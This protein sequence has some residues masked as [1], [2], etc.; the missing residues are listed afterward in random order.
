[1]V[2]T[3]I[4]WLEARDAEHTTEHKTASQCPQT[5]STQAQMPFC[6]LTGS[7]LQ[8]DHS[9]PARQNGLEGRQ[10]AG[11]ETIWKATTQSREEQ[12]GTQGKLWE[13]ENM[14]IIVM[15]VS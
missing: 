11:K 8:K 13:V 4:Q 6:E 12:E 14:I 7:A 3:G 5:R 2:A 9:G 15:I 1:M 10:T